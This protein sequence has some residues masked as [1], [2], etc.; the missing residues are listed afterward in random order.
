[1]AWIQE[2]PLA[3][4]RTADSQRLATLTS[5]P[6]WEIVEAILEPS[7]NWM[8][9][10]LVHVL[11]LEFGE[12]GSWREGF[13]VEQD[14]LFFE[15][16]VDTLDIHYQDGSGLAAYNLVTPRA[17]VRILEYMG[18]SPHGELFRLALA[19]P[20]EEGGTLSDRLPGLE[21]SLFGKTGTISH[22]NSLSG[23]LT[24]YS[25]RELIF[26]ILTNGSGLSSGLVRSSIDQVVQA[27]ARR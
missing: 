11:G 14:F 10:Q 27:V 8:T 26:S 4:E 3:K 7:Q 12:E 16:G 13:D 18:D 21:G 9:E 20:G 25:G 15:V 19:E 24:T 2:D 6:L 23:Y 22:V 17:M 1:M 5:P